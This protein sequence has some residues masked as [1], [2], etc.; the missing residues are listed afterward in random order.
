MWGVF[1][2][3]KRSPMSSKSIR[4]SY[5]FNAFHKQHPEIYTLYKLCAFELVKRNVRKISSDFIL[6]K[7]RWD[8]IAADKHIRINNDYSAHYARK[9]VKDY[10]NY[11][12]SFYFR[13]GPA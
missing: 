10:P 7:I 5:S 4:E 13:A 6:H 11:G 9:F 8:M 12:G 3:S 2:I 1:L